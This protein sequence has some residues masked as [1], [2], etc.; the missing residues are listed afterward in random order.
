MADH[1]DKLRPK[2]IIATIAAVPARMRASFSHNPQLN[3]DE[4]SNL[5]GDDGQTMLDIVATATKIL[6]ETRYEISAAA[7]R[8][9][10]VLKP[11]AV[12]PSAIGLA[13]AMGD[14]NDELEK[15]EDA[16]N[17]LVEVMEVM[18]ATDWGRVNPVEGMYSVS[19]EEIGRNIARM[20]FVHV[21]T[22]EK[23]GVTN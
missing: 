9:N 22:A 19:V 1:F 6:T 11:R 21:N 14:R 16:T 10:V 8:D 3:P 13:K 12:D 20:V 7:N 15:L 2:T 4:V 23:L 5:V 18:S 17:K